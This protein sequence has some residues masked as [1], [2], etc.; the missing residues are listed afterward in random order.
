MNEKL[1][2]FNP[3]EAIKNTGNR[4]ADDRRKA[5]RRQEPASESGPVTIVE[6]RGGQERRGGIIDRRAVESG[7][8]PGSAEEYIPRE[9]VIE[10]RRELGLSEQA[11]AERLEALKSRVSDLKD[12]QQALKDLR[13]YLNFNKRGETIAADKS[14]SFEE[15]IKALDA[16]NKEHDERAMRLEEKFNLKVEDLDL[17]A[18]HGLI[19]K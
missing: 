14:L 10:L 19:G 12:F 3:N 9:K 17:A 5:D 15:K 7:V 11:V 16:L 8:G 4:S 2:G 18:D 6:R 1:G 13:E